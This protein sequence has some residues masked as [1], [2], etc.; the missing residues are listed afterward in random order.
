MARAAGGVSD[1]RNWF[2]LT[3]ALVVAGYVLLP[4]APPRLLDGFAFRNTLTQLWGADAATL[5][6]TVQ[7]PYAAVPSGHVAFAV[8]VGALLARHVGSAALRML[9]VAYP[10]LVTLVVIATANHFWLDALAGLVV[11]AVA[12]LV[13]RAAR[14]RS[15]A[16]ARTAQAAAHPGRRHASRGERPWV[17][18]P[19]RVRGV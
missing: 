18:Q 8:L 6:H 4:T 12:W 3:Q 13:V 1:A 5:A 14:V 11:A 17:V 2:L 9:G 19:R 7:S 16:P 15:R 10:V